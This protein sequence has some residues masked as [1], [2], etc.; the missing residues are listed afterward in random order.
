MP[1]RDVEPAITI[2]GAVGPRLG[3]SGMS[4]H[5]PHRG[6]YVRDQGKGGVQQHAIEWC[7]GLRSG[8][9]GGAW[10]S[11]LPAQV[12]RQICFPLRRDPSCSN[13]ST[14]LRDVPS[15]SSKPASHLML[16]RLVKKLGLAVSGDRLN[17]R[18]SLSQHTRTTF[19][20]S[21]TP[22]GTERTDEPEKAWRSLVQ[23][24]FDHNPDDPTM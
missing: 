12:R 18:G 8:G 13:L 20:L 7:A 21:S 4:V 6:A 19:D 5:G 22:L 3:G 9:G 15:L 16:G 1:G 11:W 14:V 24:H 10:R 23:V 17:V 2:R